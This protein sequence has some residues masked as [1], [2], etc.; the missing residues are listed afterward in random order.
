MKNREANADVRCILRNLPYLLLTKIVLLALVCALVFGAGAQFFEGC[1]LYTDDRVGVRSVLAQ[2][3][4]FDLRSS[5]TFSEE[6]KTS[7]RNIL[8]YALVYQDPS[9]FAVPAMIEAQLEKEEKN[10]AAQI[11]T[12]ISICAWQIRTDEIAQDNLDSGFIVR[13]GDGWRVDEDAIRAH[14]NAVYDE[15]IEGEKR[16]MDREYRE[17]MNA[18]DDLRGVY[19]AVV[20]HT[21][22][23]LVTNT[24][25]TKADQL[26][27]FFAGTQNNLIVFN[28]DD[29][30]F[31]ADTMEEF[32]PLVQEAAAEFPQEFD[33]YLSLNG[34]L[35]FNNACE[36][37]ENRCNELYRQVHALLVRM[38][39]MGSVA[40]LL[41]VLLFLVAG[42]REY[43]G[44]IKYGATDHLPNEIHLAFHAIII[45][46]M[47]E[48]FRNSV[49]IVMLTKSNDPWFPTFPEYYAV[50]GCVCLVILVLTALAAACTLKRQI[51]NKSLLSNTILAILLRRFG[52]R[53]TGEEATEETGE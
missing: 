40:A 28:S 47:V 5:V 25:C 51:K 39:V 46:S 34:G 45:L 12:V 33:F 1:R 26:Q 37:M 7:I 9:G 13:D 36:A 11:S 14:Y 20:D 8:R 31:P 17:L 15:L 48:L 24:G 18:M 3:K 22:D 23:R 6:L 10:R 2:G 29:P 27:R 30:V 38:I 42:R 35:E 21:N 32:V 43:K 41:C 4:D 19:Y 16:S 49:H 44:A 52:K 50:R 53:K